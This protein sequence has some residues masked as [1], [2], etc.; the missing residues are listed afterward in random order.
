MWRPRKSWIRRGGNE[1]S[2]ILITKFTKLENLIKKEEG[3]S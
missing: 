1:V 3:D 2:T